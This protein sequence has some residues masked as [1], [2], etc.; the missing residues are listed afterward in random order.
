MYYIFF[1]FAMMPIDP[2]GIVIHSMGQYI[3]TENGPVAAS[4]FLKSVGL[5]VHG[6]IH[7]DGTF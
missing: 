7:P 4:D 2:K 6:F 5:S 3:D 1:G